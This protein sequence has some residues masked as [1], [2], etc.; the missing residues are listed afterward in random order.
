MNNYLTFTSENEFSIEAYQEWDGTLYYSYDAEEWVEYDGYVESSDEWTGAHIIYMRGSGNTVITNESSWYIDGE[1]VR[2]IGNIETLLDYEM[3]QN[4]EHPEM[5]EYC[6]ASMFDCCES[7]TQAPEL[8]ATKLAPYCYFSMFTNCISLTEAPELP[9]TMLAEACYLCMFDSCESLTQAPELPATELCDDCYGAMFK[10]CTS[11]TQAPELP[12]TTLAS[13]CYGEMFYGCINL[14]QAPALPATTLAK[15]CYGFMFHGCTGIKMSTTQSDE[16]P[17]AY[18]IP[19]TGD[20]TTAGENALYLMFSSTGGTFMG[21]PDI[22]TTYYGAWEPAAEE[23]ALPTLT[24]LNL[25]AW[26]TGYVLGLAGHP[27]PIPI[28]D[29]ASYAH[30]PATKTLTVKQNDGTLSFGW[31]WDA[32]Q[33]D[34]EVNK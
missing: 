2:C 8:P 15:Y 12:A 23:P 18:R 14:T 9:A 31:D 26:L 1:N 17:A 19:S 13:G 27:L 6:F 29:N 21:T 24:K 34:V 10:W 11:L 33:M 20:C 5:G 16:Y 7:L 28:E 25:K 32:M 30:N 22:N 3:V 4:G